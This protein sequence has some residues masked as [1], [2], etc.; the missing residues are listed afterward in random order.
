[1]SSPRGDPATAEGSEPDVSEP[2][3]EDVVHTAQEHI[4]EFAQF[5]QKT[6]DAITKHTENVNNYQISKNTGNAILK[7]IVD[8]LT[9][10]QSF[11]EVTDKKYEQLTD[12]FNAISKTCN[13]DTRPHAHG[14]FMSCKA[15]Y[16]GTSKVN[17][18]LIAAAMRL[19]D[20][21]LALVSPRD[22][23]VVGNRLIRE[24]EREKMPRKVIA[25]CAEAVGISY[26]EEEQG[27][28]G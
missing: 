5:C 7:T 19:F 22:M 14:W 1:M 26:A 3:V 11:F 27:Q 17:E 20:R 18:G 12:T 15:I 2:D 13:P 10:A 9:M 23:K 21:M 16:D 25:D 4:S 6:K 8:T 24:M 28:E